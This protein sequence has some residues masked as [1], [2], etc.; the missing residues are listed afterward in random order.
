MYEEEFQHAFGDLRSVTERVVEKF[1][2]CGNPRNGFARIRCPDCGYER[3]LAFSCKS[4]FCPSCQARRAEEWAFWLTEHRLESVPHHHVVFTIPKMLRAYFRFDRSLLN[5]LSRAA[6]R[7]VL[8]YCQGLLGEDIRPGLIIVRQTF[9]EGA[10]FHPHLHALVTGGGWD[11]GGVW[12]PIFGWDRPVLREL[13]TAEVFR[14]LREREL[15]S[16]ERMQLIRSWRHSGFDVFVGEPIA[17]DDRRALEHVARYL[18]RAPVSLERLWYNPEAGTVTIRPLAGEGEK[19]V[20]LGAQEFIARLITHIPDVQE[21]QVI[22][23]G[24]YANASVLQ[25]KHRQAREG[26]GEASPWAPPAEEP[27]PFERRC[28]IRW[29]QLIQRVWLEDPLLCP[30][31]GGQ[32][33]IISF[34]TDL[35]VIDK[36]LRHLKWKPG[37][38]LVTSSRSPPELLAVAE[39][40]D[41][42]CVTGH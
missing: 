7:A 34:I 36:I 31:C 27:T 23:Y 40:P 20:E 37:E 26:Q 1:M 9:G 19:P 5:D 22:Y 3:L 41:V 30:N 21:R 28:R 25:R 15:L 16:A 29:A 2:D 17:P 10:R 42:C 12:R 35:P 6:H 13:F 33:Y 8:T 11:S 32:M 14:F 38:S 24:A 39:C 4:R 18:L